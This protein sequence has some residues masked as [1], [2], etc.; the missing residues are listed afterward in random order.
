MKW[1]AS[2]LVAAE[3]VWAALHEPYERGSFTAPFSTQ[4][5]DSGILSVFKNVKS[6]SLLYA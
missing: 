2:M 4:F 5:T 1:A 3:N 6:E